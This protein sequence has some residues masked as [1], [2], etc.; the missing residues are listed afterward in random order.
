MSRKDDGVL[1]DDRRKECPYR[2]CCTDAYGKRQWRSFV[3][4]EDATR[5]LDEGRA[6]AAR[7]QRA[8]GVPS[9]QVLMISESE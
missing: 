1:L 4:E 5:W 2:A 8:L 9:L 6:E 7:L 3:T